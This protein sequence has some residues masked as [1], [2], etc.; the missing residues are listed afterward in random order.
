M[1][2]TPVRRSLRTP[3]P[4]SAYVPV[5]LEASG[6]SLLESQVLT[7]LPDLS[8]RSTVPTCG[9]PS[10][11]SM[12]MSMESGWRSRCSA[13]HKAEP[14]SKL[15]ICPVRWGGVRS[16]RGSG[17]EDIDGASDRFE[18]LRA[19]IWGASRIAS[20]APEIMECLRK[21]LRG[22]PFCRVPRCVI[23]QNMPRS[24]SI[25]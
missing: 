23:Y 2:D 1:N 6:V 9:T 20:F 18:S 7:S 11:K 19:A 25:K 5:W 24:S 12:Q 10:H 15:P 22:F 16:A 17:G 4:P 3:L 14:P 21:L 13:I 8:K